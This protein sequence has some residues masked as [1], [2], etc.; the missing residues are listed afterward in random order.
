[1][2]DET[3]SE[4]KAAAVRLVVDVVYRSFDVCH[5]RRL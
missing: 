4:N 2:A 1:M 3:G 5:E